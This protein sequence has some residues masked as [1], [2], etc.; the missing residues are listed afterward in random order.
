MLTVT[1]LSTGYGESKVIFQVNIQVERQQ[2]TSL[3]GSNAAGKTT[4]LNTI[5][6]LNRAWGGK[7]EFLG[8]DITAL[9]PRQRVE[10]GL[11]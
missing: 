3:V 10:R 9:T 2:V 5:S 6:G 8:E 11:I 4:L 1:E 7:I